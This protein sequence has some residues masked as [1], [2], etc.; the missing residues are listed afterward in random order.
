M[1][2][3]AEEVSEIIAEGEVIEAYPADR[4]YSSHLILG[5]IGKNSVHVVVARDQQTGNC[6]VIT[7]YPPDP[8]LWSEDFRTRRN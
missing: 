4:P 1:E 6:Y 3:G 2:A 8:A 7:A 5:H